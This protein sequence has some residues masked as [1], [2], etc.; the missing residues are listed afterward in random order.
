M[1]IPVPPHSYCGGSVFG[2]VLKGS[3]SV[4]STVVTYER[5]TG[6]SAEQSRSNSS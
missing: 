5:W 3:V 6:M 4:L 1:M 2:I